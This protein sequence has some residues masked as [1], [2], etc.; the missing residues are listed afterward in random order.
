MTARSK[1]EGGLRASDFAD[2]SAKFHRRLRPRRTSRDKFS[3]NLT[4]DAIKSWHLQRVDAHEQPPDPYQK[5]ERAS[6]KVTR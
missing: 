4:I 2:L 6:L 3:P 1:S 5:I